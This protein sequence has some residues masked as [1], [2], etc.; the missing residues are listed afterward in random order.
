MAREQIH[1]VGQ[2]VLRQIAGEYVLIP[3]G[4]TAM[5]VQ[6]L[7]CL[8]ESS[9]MLWKLVTEG[10]TEEALQQALLDTYEVDPETAREDTQTFLRTMRGL[11]LI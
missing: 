7:I 3:T 8:T 11:G 4:E 5:K 10:T 6:K 1:S 2:T 9:A